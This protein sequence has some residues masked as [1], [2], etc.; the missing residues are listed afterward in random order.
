MKDKIISTH[1]RHLKVW[2]FTY[3]KYMSNYKK[4]CQITKTGKLTL[5]LKDLY[6]AFSDFHFI[7]RF[8]KVGRSEQS[9]FG[10]LNDPNLIF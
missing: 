1:K 4:T 8:N 2:N 9:T 10:I 5:L 6:C 7:S 3:M